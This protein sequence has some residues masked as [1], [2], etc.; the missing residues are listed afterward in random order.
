MRRKIIKKNN[1]LRNKKR[2][3]PNI[4]KT[5]PDKKKHPIW[6][7]LILLLIPV[8][9]FLML[10]FSLR[11]FNYGQDTTQWVEVVSGELMLNPDV[12]HRYFHSTKSVPYTN[13][14]S[15]SKIKS[16]NTF[17]I[18]IMGGS[19]AAGYPYSPN[20]DFGLFVKKK[21][22]IL[23][24]ETKIEVINIALT[25][26]NS[27][28]IRDLLPGVIEQKPD[29]ILFYAGHN[30]YYGSLGVGSMESIGQSRFVINFLLKLEKY[31]TFVMFRN[32]INWFLNIFTSSENDTSIKRSGTLMSRM[33]KDQTIVLNSEVYNL[34]IEQFKGNLIDILEMCKDANVPI[35]LGTLTNNLRD[36]KPFVSLKTN[37]L[38]E[39]DEVFMQAQ[40]QLEN[41]D[42]ALKL[43]RYAKDLDGL[44]FRAPE[45][46][47]EL[48][49]KLGVEYNFPVVEIDSIFNS[50][51]PLGITGNNLMTDHLH[52][53]FDGY[54]LIGKAYFDSMDKYLLLPSSGRMILDKNIVDSLTNK[55]TFITKLDSIIAHYR[56]L[57]LKNDWPYSEQKTVSYMLNLFNQQNFIDSL[58]VRVLDN[59]YTWERAHR[60]AAEY[61]I[62]KKDYDEFIREMT[63]LINQYP[64]VKE[65]YTFVSEQLLEAKLYNEAYWFLGKGQLR[66]PG[67]FFAKW[68]GIIDLSKEKIDSAIKYLNESLIYDGKDAQVLFNL[69]GA[70]AKMKM[71]FEA[72]DAINRCLS[73]NPNYPGA[74]N[75][76]N[77][78]LAILNN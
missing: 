45:K 3:D 65:Y 41:R 62:T 33:A 24:P 30:E 75:L 35:I 56:I 57:V 66:F 12:G 16:E 48:I 1:D 44:R 76:K 61:Y 70:Y 38:P 69:T 39:A 26:T 68:L 11:I 42:E 27:Y 64:F 6:F 51:S 73:I 21:L 50:V 15:F 7:N 67:A 2:K 55:N 43:F 59:K 9:C 25:A 10:E 58:A 53:T 37:D 36:Q 63:V 22:E 40:D 28:T 52:T 49:I 20:G 32:F 60:E 31:K 5:E 47:N 78:L 18:F 46:I 4:Y 34:G 19:S 74:Q 72:L 71:F 8:F 77:Q 13:Q 23:Y 29:L 14:N 17:R 54:K